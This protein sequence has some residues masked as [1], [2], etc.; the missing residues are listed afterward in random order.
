MSLLSQGYA[1]L[2]ETRFDQ[3]EP[4]LETLRREVI[5]LG[6][7]LRSVEIELGPSQCEFTFHPQMGLAPATP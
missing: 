3:M 7:P 1:Y 2:T 6:L 5:A 4:V